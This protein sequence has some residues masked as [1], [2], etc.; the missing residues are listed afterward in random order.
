MMVREVMV[1][2]VMVRGGDGARGGGERGDER[3]GSGIHAPLVAALKYCLVNQ[4][5]LILPE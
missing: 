4:R 2:E 3:D 1:R 5:L